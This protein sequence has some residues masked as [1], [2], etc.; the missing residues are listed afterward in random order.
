MVSGFLRGCLE[1]LVQRLG[2][3][4]APGVVAV[5]E[6]AFFLQE[7]NALKALE[8]IAALCDGALGFQTGMH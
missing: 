6:T 2:L 5:M 3:G 7:I 1:E 4:E 8:D